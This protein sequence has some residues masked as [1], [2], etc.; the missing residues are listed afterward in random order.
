MTE[1]VFEER[2]APPLGWYAFG[3][4]AIG[5]VWALVIS[6]RLDELQWELLV[7]P[8]F[9]V[10]VATIRMR[11]VVTRTHLRITIV[12]IPRKAVDVAD[13][14]RCEP[15]TYRPLMHYGGWGWRWSPSRGWAYTMRGKRGV[16]IRRTN[17]K[18]FLV[19]SQRPEELAA[20][21]E[22]VR[23]GRPSGA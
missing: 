21:I 14:E 22:S 20:A 9:A 7:L 13:V 10:V 17:G 23:Q 6:A 11:T 16:M 1:P 12:P 19:G 3:L 4:F 15:V 18:S 8:G 2:Q 5:L